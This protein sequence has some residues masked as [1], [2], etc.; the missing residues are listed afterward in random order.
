MFRCA[1]CLTE[2]TGPK[3]DWLGKRRGGEVEKLEKKAHKGGGSAGVPVLGGVPSK[4][5]KGKKV[6]KDKAKR[7]RQRSLGGF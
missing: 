7:E 5:A 2:R 6:P 3:A 1:S 4:E